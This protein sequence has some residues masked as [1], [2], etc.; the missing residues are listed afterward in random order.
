MFWTRALATVTV[1]VDEHA[2]GV[3]L[4]YDRMARLLAAYGNRDA[5]QIAEDL[6]NESGALLRGGLIVSWR[7]D[8]SEDRYSIGESLERDR[9]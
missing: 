9:L 2:D 7:R 4:S 1:L 6:D 5:L 8:G 3:H